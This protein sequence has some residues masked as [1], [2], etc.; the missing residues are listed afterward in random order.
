MRRA[1]LVTSVLILAV[2]ARAADWPNFTGGGDFTP[3][4]EGR[5]L[6]DHLD[7]APVLWHL[8]HHMGVGKGLY[9]GSLREC[10]DRGIEAFYGGT[11]TPVVSDEIVYVSY[12]KPNGKVPAKR[13][14]W[15]TMPE[16]NLDLLPDWFFSVTADDCLI[17][18]DA[19]TG[20]V[21]WRAVDVR[22]ERI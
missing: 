14:G 22:K 7:D 18:V 4:D 6:V 5:K 16:K 13:E 2:A 21:K 1:F 10:R 20:Q 17:A 3:P 9:P 11:S 19:E 15:R 8:K 12:F